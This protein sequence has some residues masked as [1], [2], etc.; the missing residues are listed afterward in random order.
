MPLGFTALIR[1]NTVHVGNRIVMD[2]LKSSP[3]NHKSINHNQSINQS[4]P[5]TLPNLPTKVTDINSNNHHSS[6]KKVERERKIDTSTE[7][8]ILI[9][10]Y[11]T[12]QLPQ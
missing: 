7:N 6:Q 8:T 10:F 9:H 5:T 3:V 4:T 1:K 11:E 12:L 2:T